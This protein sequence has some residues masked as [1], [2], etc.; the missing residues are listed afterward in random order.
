MKLVEREKRVVENFLKEEDKDFKAICYCGDLENFV[1]Y[2]KDVKKVEVN[3]WIVEL[4]KDGNQ[5]LNLDL[6]F[7]IMV[8]NTHAVLVRTLKV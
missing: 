6:P 5:K 7:T 1:K 2:L 3:V 4:K 8:K